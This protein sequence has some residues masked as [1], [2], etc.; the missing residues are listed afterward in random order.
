MVSRPDMSLWAVDP[1]PG[2]HEGERP[3]LK[4]TTQEAAVT[5]LLDGAGCWGGY[6]GTCH[7]RSHFV[8]VGTVVSRSKGR[9]GD[10]VTMTVFLPYRPYG[11]TRTYMVPVLDNLFAHFVL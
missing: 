10:G 3:P 9:M 8:S 1:S 4:G 5:S 7:L 11:P 6:W 2:A